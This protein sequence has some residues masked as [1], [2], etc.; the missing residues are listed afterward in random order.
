LV[1]V[2][3]PSVPARLGVVVVFPKGGAERRYA[4]VTE[5][6]RKIASIAT[7]PKINGTKSVIATS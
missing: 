4:S 1:D 3:R 5:K 2:S 7:V 6:N